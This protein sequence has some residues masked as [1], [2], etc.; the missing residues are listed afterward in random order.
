MPDGRGWCS[1]TM[2][3]CYGCSDN[4][5]PGSP[6]PFKPEPQVITLKQEARKI[7]VKEVKPKEVKVISRSKKIKPPQTQLF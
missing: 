7:K 1:I 6:K 4:F 3:I 2:S 5:K